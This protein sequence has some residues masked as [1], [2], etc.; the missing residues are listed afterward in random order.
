MSQETL[1]AIATAAHQ[2]GAI[3]LL[4]SLFFLLFILRPV[5]RQALGVSDRQRFFLLL[6]RYLFRWLWVALLLLWGSGGWQIYLLGA[7]KPPLTVEIMAGG[8]ALITAL[9]ML[10]QV[11]RYFHLADFVE[12]ERWPQ[13][14]RYSSLVRVLMAGA[15]LI[16]LVLLLTGVGAPYL[17]PPPP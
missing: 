10:G 8:G 9:T 11:V 5:T 13:A 16:G 7:A 2:L 4:G 3:M 12:E 1:S 17:A 15:L 6:Y 14:G